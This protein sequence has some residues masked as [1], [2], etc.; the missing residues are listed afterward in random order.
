[1]Q[2]LMLARRAKRQA[3]RQDDPAARAQVE[4]AKQ[5]L[6]ERGPV[7]WD[8]GAPDYTSH[9]APTSSYADWVAGLAALP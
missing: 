8:D 4:A 6:G 9:L 7:W 1:V 5:G 3:M 2:T